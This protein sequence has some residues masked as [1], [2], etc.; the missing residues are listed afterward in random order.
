MRSLGS[1]CLFLILV[2]VLACQRTGGF[3]IVPST[4]AVLPG[5][6][7]DFTSTGQSAGAV[8]FTVVTNNSGATIDGNTGVYTAGQTANVTDTVRATD[9]AG[10]TSDAS[11]R[12][13]LLPVP[14]VVGQP[15][16][17]SIS[18]N[19]GAGG[20]RASAMSGPSGVYS[21]G[22]HL[23][24]ADAGNQR[25]LIWNSIPT[26]AD[27]PANVVLGQ[28]NM[29]SS[30]T[31]SGV[32]AQTLGQPV[33]LY[34]DGTRLFV[35]D[36]GYGRV[37]IW[38]SIPVFD[39]AP[40]S[41]VIGQ[42]NMFSS[43]PGDDA[44]TLGNPISVSSDGRRL[45]VSDLG[46]SR[47]LIWNTIPQASGAAANVVVGQPNMTSTGQ[48][49]GGISARSLNSP[50]SAYSDGTSLYVADSSNNRVL[51]WTSIPTAD[52][53]EAD[54]VLGQ[55]SMASSV[56]NSGGIKAGSLYQP[57]SVFVAG[58]SLYVSDS[59][60]NRVLA[61]NAIPSVNGA[62]ASFVVGQP[63][64]STGTPDN[65]GVGASRLYG[66]MGI[67]VDESYLFVSDQGN[68]RVLIL[69]AP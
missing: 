20:A 1:F 46:N 35:A 38:N 27:V 33:G 29:T 30:G 44:R 69:S 60:N 15:D 4:P 19:Q 52:G 54:V 36:E 34:S 11:V 45:Y 12:V 28:P 56:A 50:E 31:N 62:A 7:I 17:V 14:L 67:F 24:V 65:G 55:S 48:N 43:N 40:A 39:Y 63:G 16:F 68:N 53:A 57:T 10:T 9:S 23:F 61:W 18:P 2:P 25:V 51:I 32:T 47:V 42:P 64:M 59:A 37:L 8:T 6:T 22:I 26:S 49:N 21:D 13:I 3:A 41:V 66:P 58:S 5:A